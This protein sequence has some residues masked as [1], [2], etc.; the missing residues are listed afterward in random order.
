MLELIYKMQPLDYVYL[1]RRGL[2]YLS[3]PFNHSL[4]KNINIV[5]VQAYSGSCIACP[6]SLALIYLREINGWL[7]IAMAAV[8]LVKTTWQRPLL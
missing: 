7:V 5:S 2:F 6:L 8:V 1:P 3:L 4:I